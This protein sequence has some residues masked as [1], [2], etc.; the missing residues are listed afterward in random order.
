MKLYT[1]Q[2]QNIYSRSEKLIYP[3]PHTNTQVI[4]MDGT[5]NMMVTSIEDPYLLHYPVGRD[6]GRPGRRPFPLKR[7]NPLGVTPVEE[8]DE[9]LDY[10]G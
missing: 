3:R 9:D 8:P 2:Y 4:S 6:G 10:I 7:P 5:V 1:L